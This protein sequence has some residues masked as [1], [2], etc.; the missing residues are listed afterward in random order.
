[1]QLTPRAAPPTQLLQCGLD[2]A[3]H[4]SGQNNITNHSNRICASIESR[5][6]TLCAHS[7]NRNNRQMDLGTNGLELI[8]PS[9]GITGGLC[10]RAKQRTKADI[11]STPTLCCGRLGQ[12]MG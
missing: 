4:V 6:R 12:V 10:L 5:E 1:M 11:I 2:F 3:S 8:K 7:P 9:R